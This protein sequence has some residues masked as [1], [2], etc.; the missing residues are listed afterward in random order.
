VK[1]DLKATSHDET[2]RNLAVFIE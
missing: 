2:F 1:C